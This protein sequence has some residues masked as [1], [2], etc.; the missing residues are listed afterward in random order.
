MV[1]RGAETFHSQAKFG[2]RSGGIFLDDVACNGAESN[3]G[4][5]N[6]AG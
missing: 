4:E 1:F 3:L 5:C 2:H 6:H